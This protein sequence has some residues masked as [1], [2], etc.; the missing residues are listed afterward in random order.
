VGFKSQRHRHKET[1]KPQKFMMKQ[2]KRWYEWHHHLG[3]GSKSWGS[4]H[5]QS[6]PVV[7]VRF[8]EHFSALGVACNFTCFNR[9]VCIFLLPPLLI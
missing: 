7:D 2:K 1:I 5:K 3:A 9:L 6:M 8:F 4:Y